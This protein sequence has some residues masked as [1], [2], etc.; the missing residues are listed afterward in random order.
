MGK[1]KIENSN[2]IKNVKLWNDFEHQQSFY[3]LA[4]ENRK[5]YENDGEAK[6]L[7]NCL[8]MKVTPLP[9]FCR[10]DNNRVKKT[11]IPTVL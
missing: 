11:L 8:K 3:K 9:A 5:V 6:F 4:K 10:S 1:T 7:E 2:R